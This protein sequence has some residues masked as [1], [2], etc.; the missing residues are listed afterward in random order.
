MEYGFHRVIKKKGSIPQAAYILDNEPVIKTPYE[1]L[2][3]VLFLNLDSTSMKQIKDNYSDPAERIMEI[4]NERGKMHNPIT[5]SGGV[6][7]GRVKDYGSRRKDLTKGYTLVPLSSLSTMPLKLDKIKGIK[8]DQV[9]VKGTAVLFESTPFTYVPSDFDLETSLAAVDI[10]SIVPQTY[11][12]IKGKKSMLVIGVGKAGITA[13]AAARKAEP[14][15]YIAGFEFDQRNIEIARQLGLANELFGV[16][17]T[18]PQQVYD[19]AMGATANEMFDLVLNCVNVQNTEASAILAAKEHGTV[20]FFSMAT[21]FDKAALGT[22]ATGKDVRMLI[23]NGVAENQAE[24]TFDLL[25]ENK[26]LKK[27]FENHCK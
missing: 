11:R 16:D 2:A 22:D 3:D 25:R 9:E 23:G 26:E 5:N 24:L 1:A 21:Q 8:G 12:E 17:A 19:L 27:Y 18:N 6:F 15:L 7:V 4:V 13:M 10:S 14:D 20:M